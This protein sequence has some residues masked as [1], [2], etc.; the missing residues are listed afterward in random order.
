MGGFRKSLKREWKEHLKGLTFRNI[1]RHEES[2]ERMER[3]LRATNSHQDAGAEESQERMESISP[4]HLH[5]LASKHREESQERME[6][7]NND[8]Y[9]LD[10]I[11]QGERRS[12][13]E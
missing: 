4:W 8:T 12:Q 5:H 2:Q 7:R 13:R 1:S 11:Y 10:V 9:A 3:H 6:R